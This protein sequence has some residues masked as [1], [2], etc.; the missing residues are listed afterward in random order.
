MERVLDNK[1]HPSKATPKREA[2]ASG[3]EH[4]SDVGNEDDGEDEEPQVQEQD[5]YV[6]NQEPNITNKVQEHDDHEHMVI[7][8]TNP[9]SSILLT[10]AL[11]IHSIIEGI[12]IGATVSFQLLLM[13]IFLLWVL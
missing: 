13:P 3:K 2:S 8:A 4:I 11:S 10:M 7:D 5:D 1:M 6:D 9:L 12:G